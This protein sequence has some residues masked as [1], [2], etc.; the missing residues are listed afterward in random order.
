MTFDNIQ[1]PRMTQQKT[2][3]NDISSENNCALTPQYE[4]LQIKK[5]FANSVIPHEIVEILRSQ[6][7]GLTSRQIV[8]KSN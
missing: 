1:M 4:N 5:M 8:V 6:Q 2:G 7:D 3:K